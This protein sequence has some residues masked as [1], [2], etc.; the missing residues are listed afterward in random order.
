MADIKKFIEDE[1]SMIIAPAGYGKTYTIVEAVKE[2][3]D[4]KKILVLTHT[5]AGIASLK[6]KFKLAKVHP[7]KYSL[8]TI[9]GFSLSFANSYHI[10]KNDLVPENDDYFVSAVKIA[11]KLLN[12]NPIKKA[13]QAKYSHLIVDEYQD[14]TIDQHELI[15]VIACIIKTHILGDPLQGIFNFKEKSVNMESKE[16]MNSFLQ[17][18]QSLSTPWR[19]LNAERPDLGRALMQIRNL[20]ENSRSINLLEFNEVADIHICNTDYSPGSD[21]RSLIQSILINNQ[22]DSLLFIHPVSAIPEPRINFIQQFPQV[23]MVEAID[24]KI[25]YKYSRQF[26]E[27]NGNDLV[28]SIVNFM[29]EV[30]KKTI[31]NYWF[32]TTGKLKNKKD[33]REKIISGRLNLYVQNIIA[34]KSYDNILILIE[35]ILQLPNNKCYRHEFVYSM[36]KALKDTVSE[37][38]SVLELMKRNR[39]II[40]RT[41]RHIYGKCIGTTLL[42]KGLEFDVV[43]VLNAHQFEDPKNL[44]VALTRAAKQLIIVSN[45]PM[46]SPYKKK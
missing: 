16:Q 39:D 46:L 13:I 36:K 14:C 15:L 35:K 6:D 32:S 37:N 40:R 19:W 11:A 30:C 8:E 23:K 29:R 12:A 26:D 33:S 21:F 34:S 31:I 27:Y 22:T 7:S 24:D 28:A 25:L 4:E 17:N 42:T 5:H 45:T 3:D 2:L 18:R 20:I 9:T 41:G 44:Y 38:P 43:V 1:K 10:N